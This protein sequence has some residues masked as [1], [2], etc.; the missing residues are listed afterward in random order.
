MY[1]EFLNNSKN[2]HFNQ[3]AF[4]QSRYSNTTAGWFA[5]EVKAVIEFDEA[6]KAAYDFYLRHPDETLI[7]VTA[8]HGT[9]GVALGYGE[10]GRDWIFWDKIE[11]AWIEAGE[12]NDLDEKTNKALNDES[13]IGWTTVYHTGENVPVYAIGKGAE[14]FGGK[15]DNTEIKGRILGR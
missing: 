7:V 10:W 14:R 13:T 9:G 5:C 2:L 6:V 11:K 15:M 12:C 3:C 1:A 8:D 4:R